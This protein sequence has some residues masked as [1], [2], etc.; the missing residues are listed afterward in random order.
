MFLSLRHF[1][2]SAKLFRRPQ[3]KRL[4]TLHPSLELLEDR[5]VP[6]TFTVT[7]THDSGTNSL[8]QAILNS[9]AHPGT[10]GPNLIDF[11]LPTNSN[12]EIVPNSALPAITS[13]VVINGIPVGGP[14]VV[15]IGNNTG[16][17]NG[18]TLDA[19]GCTI[20][21]MEI[22]GFASAGIL[23]N[24][25]N[26]L[27]E[28]NSL[29]EL[30]GPDPNGTGIV[31]EGS[32]NT[33]GG[34]TA[35]AAN[36]VTLNIDSGIVIES[37]QHNQ[38]EGNFIGVNSKGQS[39]GN[40][41]DGVKIEG[42]ASQNNIVGGIVAGTANVISCND[43]VG[44][45]II[46][47]ATANTVEGNFI[48][49]NLGGTSDSHLGNQEDGVY[50]GSGANDNFIGNTI[51][52]IEGKLV[53]IGN[54]ISGNGEYGVEITGAGTETN[55]LISNEIGTN[56]GGTA[57]LGNKLGGVLIHGGATDNLIGGGTLNLANFISGNDS[58]G[59]VISGKG[60]TGNIVENNRIGTTMDGTKALPNLTYGAMIEAGATGNFI[61]VAGGGNLISG[62]TN[63]SGVYIADAGTSHN[64]VAG[65]LIGTNVND[66]GPLKNL[67]GVTIGAGATDNTIGGAAAGD[68]NVISGNADEGVIITDTD[69]NGNVLEGNDIGTDLT[70]TMAIPNGD[71]GVAIEN[72]ASANTIGGTS[73]A[74]AN[75]ISGNTDDGIHITGTGTDKNVVAEN[76]IGTDS[77]GTVALANGAIGVL[78]NGGASD[79]TVGDGNVISGNTLDGV[80]LEGAGSKGNNIQYNL[81]GLN[82]SG[83]G[84]LPNK[85]D[86]VHF[87]EGAA[88]NGVYNNVI[89]GNTY[90]GIYLTGA[91]TEDNGFHGNL[92]GTEADGVTPLPNSYGVFIEGSSNNNVIGGPNSGNTIADN[93][94]AGIAITGNG[95]VSNT[96]SRNSIYGNGTVGIDL[97]D[98]GV[99]SIN[100]S[101]GPHTGPNHLQ[102]YP[103]LTSITVSGT[104]DVLHGTLN[105]AKM[106]SFTIEVFSSPS[107]DQGETYLGTVNVGTDNHGNASFT[108]TFNP[109]AASPYLTATA[110]DVNG[111][112]SE[113]SAP[114][115]PSNGISGVVALPSEV[116]NFSLASFIPAL[117]AA[118][119]SFAGGAPSGA[120]GAP[121]AS[122]AQ[123]AT[124]FQEIQG[125]LVS[126]DPFGQDADW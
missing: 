102:N 4:R 104:S 74:S 39:E 18:L 38:I 76:L 16:Q 95:S 25:S 46:T 90:N 70:G 30:G 123:I 1:A 114:L 47:D 32:N 92:I 24:S 124:A 50:I 115:A 43:G 79:N 45:G 11:D 62:N 48:G 68:A 54:V 10:S 33:I 56:A 29:G 64:T 66:N 17:S 9:N 6:T 103:V 87:D 105:G 61:G 75:I 41:L 82:S 125:Q 23:V 22:G 31:I 3:T 108:F 52:G 80:R 59:V 77:S 110:T 19:S 34:T 112:T 122:P 44:V 86:G 119:E 72:A 96:I 106:S 85:E 53:G 63:H 73:Q 35:A 120:P 113:F 12:G 100:T 65:N 98:T 14:L 49:T 93:T 94:H 109:S 117:T 7:N 5:L 42:A 91:T 27:I 116:S 97:G 118:F 89:S 20:E 71:S 8:R 111:N 107:G 15:L 60:T 40:G 55:L 21:S 78:I 13:P 81:I 126:T 2:R 37:G 69:T 67:V 121:P 36:V 101:G 99:Q 58:Q 83:T 88:A 28:G 84:A 57:A 26:N 51:T